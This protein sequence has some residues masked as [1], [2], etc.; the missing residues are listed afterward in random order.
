MTGAER[1]NSL[2]HAS[3]ET[4]TSSTPS[5][6]T[7]ITVARAIAGPTAACHAK[8]I[9]SGDVGARLT[10]SATAA[11]RTCWMGCIFTL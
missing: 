2:R 9:F 7:A 4:L 5:A 11:G 3:V 1:F 8:A 10:I 6:P